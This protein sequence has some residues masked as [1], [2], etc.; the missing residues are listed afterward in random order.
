MKMLAQDPRKTQLIR[1]QQVICYTVEFMHG[2]FF[3][4]ITFY[5]HNLA[6]VAHNW[7]FLLATLVIILYMARR[8]L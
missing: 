4:C 6:L 2:R 1:L 8:T 5:L 3:S 7:H